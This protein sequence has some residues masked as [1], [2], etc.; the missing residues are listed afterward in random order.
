M[1]LPFNQRRARWGMLVVVIVLVLAVFL[2]RGCKGGQRLVGEA[3]GWV[4]SMEDVTTEELKEFQPLVEHLSSADPPGDNS[5]V[6][7][8]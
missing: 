5:R 2:V 1:S 3:A 8:L 7:R 6:R 4:E